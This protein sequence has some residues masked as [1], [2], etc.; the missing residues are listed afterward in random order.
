MDYYLKLALLGGGVVIIGGGVLLHEWNNRRRAK[1]LL[2]TRPALDPVA[3]GRVYFAESDRRALLAAQVREVLAEHVPYSLEGLGPDDAFVQDLRMDE[4][5]SMST[6]ELVLSLEKRF[7]IKIPEDDAQ[8]ILSFR[9]LVDYLEERVPDDR[10]TRGSERAGEQ[11][12]AADE[13]RG[14]TGGARS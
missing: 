10:L 9:D 13:R 4:L 2:A 1:R 7:G 6:V 3:F 12:D 14:P 8:T 11:A 5:D